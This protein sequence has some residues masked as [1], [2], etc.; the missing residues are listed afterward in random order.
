MKNHPCDVR[1]GGAVVVGELVVGELVVGELVVGDEVVL[2]DAV[3]GE[4]VVLVA[5]GVGDVWVHTVESGVG[6]VVG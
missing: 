3:D 4:E 2:G 6:R 5:P 1:C